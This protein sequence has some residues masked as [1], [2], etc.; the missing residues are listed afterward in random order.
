MIGSLIILLVFSIFIS[1][2]VYDVQRFKKQKPEKV[3]EMSDL[4]EEIKI[5]G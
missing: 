3:K 1:K 4:T 2:L 5:E